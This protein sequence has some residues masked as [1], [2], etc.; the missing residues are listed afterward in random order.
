MTWVRIVA[1]SEVSS[2]FLS[3]Q[4]PLLRAYRFG[5]P[6]ALDAFC[7]STASL[8]MPNRSWFLLA[9]SSTSSVVTVVRPA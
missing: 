4:M 6:F 3:N 5:F 2:H 1:H 8:M 7:W 9:S